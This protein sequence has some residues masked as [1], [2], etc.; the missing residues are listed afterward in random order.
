MRLFQELNFS[1]LTIVLVTHEPDIA[2][3]A[4]RVI[5][6]HDGVVAADHA[7]QP[8]SNTQRAAG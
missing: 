7:S 4:R 8:W 5:T 3:E 2:A 1:G 6:F